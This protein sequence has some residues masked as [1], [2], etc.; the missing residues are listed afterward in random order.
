MVYS[1]AD[2]KKAVIFTRNF[3]MESLKNSS[4][5]NV[6]RVIQMPDDQ[7][8]TEVLRAAIQAQSPSTTKSDS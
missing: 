2:L 5:A 7:F 4:T 3:V 8:Y 6:A 1:E